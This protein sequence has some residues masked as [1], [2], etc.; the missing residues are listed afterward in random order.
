[1]KLSKTDIVCIVLMLAIPVAAMILVSHIMPG[2]I[3]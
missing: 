3:V 2:V 1:M